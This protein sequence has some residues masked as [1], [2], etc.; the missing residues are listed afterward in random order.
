[1]FCLFTDTVNPW[2]I[3]STTSGSK[4]C[5]LTNML[6]STPT[7]T[8]NYMKQPGEFERCESTLLSGWYRF[9]YYEPISTTPVVAGQCGSSAPIY[10][11]GMKINGSLV[12]GVQCHFQQYFIY[13]VTVS[14]IDGGNQ[15]NRRRTPTCCKSL[16]RVHL[17]MNGVRTHN[18][19]VKIN[20]ISKV[21]TKLNIY[22]SE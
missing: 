15:I 8:V 14:F 22:S 9:S 20:E 7:R 1:M 4:A 13:I 6:D 19:S 12:Y 16:H 11:Q 10:L 3:P 21:V 5:A 18:F 2:G 17:T